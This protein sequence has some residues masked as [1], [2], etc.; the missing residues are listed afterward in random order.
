MSNKDKVQVM[1]RAD[2]ELRDW[3][4]QESDDS[5]RSVQWL[6]TH[7]VELWRKRLLRNRSSAVSKAGKKSDG[8]SGG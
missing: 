3:L 7:A 5:G 1:W 8:D 2:P 6:I 4:Q